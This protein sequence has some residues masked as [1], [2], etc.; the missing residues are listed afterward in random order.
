MRFWDSSALVPLLVD[1][2]QSAELRGLPEEDIAV[3]WAT[4][5]ECASALARLERECPRGADFMALNQSLDRASRGWR[6]VAPSDTRLSWG[7]RAPS[8]GPA[9]VKEIKGLAVRLL[10]QHAL[11]AADATQF[12][13]A[14][15]ASPTRADLLPFVCLDERLLAAAAQEGFPLLPA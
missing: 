4:E 15:V 2:K 10:R 6:Q 14:L 3:W 12:A 11:R 7:Y 13:A 5:V 1:Q 8:S 9:P